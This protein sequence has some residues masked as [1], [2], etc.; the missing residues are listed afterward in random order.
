MSSADLGEPE[1]FM[2]ADIVTKNS[3]SKPNLTQPASLPIRDCWSSKKGIFI[4]T[5]MCPRTSRVKRI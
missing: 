4:T 1:K 2:M 3:K 5:P